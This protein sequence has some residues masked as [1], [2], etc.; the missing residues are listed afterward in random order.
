[1]KDSPVYLNETW[2][3]HVSSCAEGEACAGLGETHPSKHIPAPAPMAPLPRAVGH[4]AQPVHSPN[5]PSRLLRTALPWRNMHKS[6]KNH[7]RHDIRVILNKRKQS[8][9]YRPSQHP[10]LG[11]NQ[12]HEYQW[13]LLQHSVKY[14]ANTWTELTVNSACKT[15]VTWATSN[16]FTR[17]NLFC[18]VHANS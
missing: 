2:E 17:S 12:H 8:N 15:K 6:P 9:R 7:N 14:L 13:K 3:P 16:T 1:M 10:G 4:R 5:I 18:T 11:F